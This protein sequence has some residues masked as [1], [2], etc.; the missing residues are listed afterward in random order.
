MTVE[1]LKAILLIVKFCESQNN[2]KTCPIKDMC[3]KMPSEW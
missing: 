2:C 3:G 1:L